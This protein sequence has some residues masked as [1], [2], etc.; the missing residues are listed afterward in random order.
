[1]ATQFVERMAVETD[2]RATPC[3]LMHG[4]G[5]TSNVW[6]P[7]MP[8]LSR[9]RTVR[10]DLPGSRALG[11]RRGPALDRRASCRRCC[12]SAPRLHV[13]RAHVVAHSMGTIVAS[14]SPCGARS[15]CAAWRCSARCSRR[16][17][18]RGRPCG[19][20]AQKARSEG[21]AGMQE[22]A[23]A[24]VQAR[25]LGRDPRAPAAAVA[26]VRESLMRQMPEGYARSCEALAEAQPADVDA[27]RAARRCWSPATRTRSRRRR[28][29]ARSASA[30]PAARGRGPAALRPLDDDREARANATTLLRR[31]TRGASDETERRR[32]PW[33]TC[34]SPTCASSTARGAQPYAG[35]VLVQGNRIP[36][37]GRGARSL[38]TAGATVI[39]GAGRHADAGHGRGAH[40]LLVERR[41]RRSTA[42]S[43]CRSRSTCCGRADVAKRYLDA[44]WTSCVGAACAKPRLDVVI[45]NAIN[46]GLIP[47]PRYLAASQ[48]ITVAGRPR[49]RDAAAPAV[50]RVQLRR[51]R[52]RAGGDAQGR[53]HVPQ[54]RRRLDQAQPVG[55]QLRRRRAGRARP[56]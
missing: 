38:P 22:I 3:L 40:A 4:L 48:E 45:R 56:G 21:V 47:G 51:R 23:D 1:M 13:E 54:V 29:C 6:T 49:R 24:L 18:P 36:R 15:W 44:G 5:G 9:H 52:Q 43:A 20:A 35:E 46:E 55:R 11:A 19:R 32:Q 26:F 42:S 30:S 16:P 37:V 17:T 53:A 41:S 7:L 10:P 39:D 28:R 14:T 50:S 12:G 2:G 27:D 25:D 8:A 34:S 31:S 33:R